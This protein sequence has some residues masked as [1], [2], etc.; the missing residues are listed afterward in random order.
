MRSETLDDLDVELCEAF[1]FGAY[2]SSHEAFAVIKEELDE[3]W[4][5]IKKKEYERDPAALKDEAIQVAATALKYADQ[6]WGLW[7]PNSE[8]RTP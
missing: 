6:V 7:R 3:L 8:A 5:E 4:E 2:A 1:A